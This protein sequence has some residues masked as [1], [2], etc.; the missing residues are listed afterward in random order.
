M[1]AVFDRTGRIKTAVAHQF[2]SFASVTTIIDMKKRNLLFFT[3]FVILSSAGYAQEIVNGGFEMPSQKSISRNWIVELGKSAYTIQLDS[4]EKHSGKY[5]L[6]L[7][8]TSAAAHA[9]KK[10]AIIAN[11]FGMGS[12]QKVATVEI[13]AWVKY[14]NAGDS[15]IALFF[16]PA[17]GNKIIRSYVKDFQHNAQQWQQITLT[18]EAEKDKPLFGFYYGFEITAKGMVWMD[19]IEIKVNGA[20]VIDPQSFRSEPTTKNIKWLNANLS[21]IRMTGKQE[22]QKDLVQ[23]GKFVASSRIVTLGEPTHGTHEAFKFKMAAI[24]YL[25]ENKGFTTIALEEV[26]PTCDIMNRVINSPNPS[27]KDSLMKLP[28]YK[29]YQTAEMVE[30]LQWVQGYNQKNPDK[31][32]KFIG[33]DMEDIQMKSSRNLLRDYGK[34]HELAIYQMIGK[35]DDHLD[36]LLAINK[37]GAKQENVVKAA[38]LLKSDFKNL[39]VL[40]TNIDKG[41]GNVQLM[42]NLRT[43]LRVCEQWLQ[44]R[45]YEGD[46]DRFMAENIEF[47]SENFPKEK[48]IVWAHN[49]HV[50]RYADQLRSTM[51]SYLKN[52]YQKDIV[53]IGFTSSQGHYTAAHDYSQ[54]N[55][56]IFPFEKAYMGTY[57]YILTRANQ[58]SYFLPLNQKAKHAPEASWLGTPMK[59]LDISY[60]RSGEDDDYKFYGN[61]DTVFDGIVFCRETTASQSYWIK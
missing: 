11:T 7:S 58:S 47:Y 32:V 35:I 34:K 41:T 1:V 49:L 37:S 8:D 60:I 27:I 24:Q 25:V 4:I 51:G 31:K 54:K 16:Q 55:W 33:M 53:S 43:Y 38:E 20:K 13:R 42:F 46:R 15:A 50:A 6:Q 56:D 48:L 17:R 45:F 61:L 40:L 10:E 28:F 52:Y 2:I 14:A 19:D 3:L 23:V 36:S 30:L 5:A 29:L 26:I 18:F 12:S 59:H 21:P 39:H 9:I 57:E 22:L 44:S